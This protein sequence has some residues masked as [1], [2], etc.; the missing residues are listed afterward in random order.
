MGYPVLDD[1]FTICLDCKDYNCAIED[2]L[3]D[4]ICKLMSSDFSG[5]TILRANEAEKPDLEPKNCT[6]GK[7]GSINCEPVMNQC[8]HKLAV[9][10]F[11]GGKYLCFHE[12]I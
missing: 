8:S 3:A 7:N 4:A 12:P 5:K 6:V 1:K 2:E 11:V 9:Y 10:C